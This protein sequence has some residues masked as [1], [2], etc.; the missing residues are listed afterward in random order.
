[1]DNIGG[2]TMDE[3]GALLGSGRKFSAEDLKQIVKAKARSDEA[4]ARRAE[5]EANVT[6]SMTNEQKLQYFQIKYGNNSGIK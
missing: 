3:L 1:M 4:K 5:A 2:V 6:S